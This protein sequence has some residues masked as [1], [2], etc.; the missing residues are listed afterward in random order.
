LHVILLS[1]FSVHFFLSLW[2]T[3]HVIVSCV[4]VSDRQCTLGYCTHWKLHG[5]TLHCTS[6]IDL[7]PLRVH[8]DVHAHTQ[9]LRN[10]IFGGQLQRVHCITYI[11]NAIL[12]VG[13]I[14]L[15]IYSSEQ[16]HSSL[17]SECIV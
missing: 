6:V 15:V 13:D 5:T 8:T 2:C 16:E 1:F 9:W 7:V 4:Y 10:I 11:L 3:M 12:L 17:S 14:T